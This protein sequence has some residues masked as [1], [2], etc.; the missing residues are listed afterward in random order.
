MLISEIL[1]FDKI[2]NIPSVLLINYII[3][4]IFLT[5]LKQK[6]CATRTRGKQDRNEEYYHDDGKTNN[7]I[8]IKNRQKRKITVHSTQKD[9]SERTTKDEEKENNNMYN[10]LQEQLCDNIQGNFWRRKLLDKN[11]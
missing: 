1:F 10:N 3:A 4:I 11:V 6:V 2:S 9:I 5:V 7:K 8:C